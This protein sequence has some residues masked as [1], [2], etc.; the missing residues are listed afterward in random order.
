MTDV[1]LQ[2]NL[3]MLYVSVCMVLSYVHVIYIYIVSL[4]R[5]IIIIILF[6]FFKLKKKIEMQEN[7]K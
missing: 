3:Q 7:E 5:K 4:D 1:R 6:N 2:G